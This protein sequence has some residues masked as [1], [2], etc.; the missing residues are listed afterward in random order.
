MFIHLHR[1]VMAHNSLETRA[2]RIC[3]PRKNMVSH[4][5]GMCTRQQSLYTRQHRLC[6]HHQS[7][8]AP[9]QGSPPLPYCPT[10]ASRSPW[11]ACI[12]FCYS[13]ITLSRTY[14]YKLQPAPPLEKSCSTPAIVLRPPRPCKPTLTASPHSKPLKARP[15]ATPLTTYYPHH[16]HRAPEPRFRRQQ[17]Q[18]PHR[19]Q[20][21]RSPRKPRF[22]RL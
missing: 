12:L 2:Q 16:H 17:A 14:F 9:R 21:N 18:T 8:R 3:T 15:P 19:Q 4:R 5:Q 10:P 13:R 6:P 22:T 1:L 7:M 20:L 11:P